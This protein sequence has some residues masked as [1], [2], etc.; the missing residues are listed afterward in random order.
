MKII[1]SKQIPPALRQLGDRWSWGASTTLLLLSYY[2]TTT[3]VLLWCY[4]CTT[5]L[6]WEEGLP[7]SL[8]SSRGPVWEGWKGAGGSFTRIGAL[9]A[10]LLCA[11]NFKAWLRSISDRFFD[12]IWTKCGPVLGRFWS[13]W[14]LP[15]AE[16]PMSTKHCKTYIETTIF[17]TQMD[18][19]AAPNWSKKGRSNLV[20]LLTLF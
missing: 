17:G 19:Q 18:P 2:S 5:L 10:S 3:L 8:P 6:L 4:S 12:E 14:A 13:I 11:F 1:N 16:R 9:L 7:S 15:I 20:A